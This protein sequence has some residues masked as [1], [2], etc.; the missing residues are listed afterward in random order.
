[1]TTKSLIR[2]WVQ[3][4][5][6]ISSVELARHAKIARQVATRHLNDLIA[7]GE[8]HRTG[9]TKS[10]LYFWGPSKQ[11]IL[12]K[13]H[14]AKTRRGLSE[15]EVFLEIESALHFKKTLS[16][17]GNQIAIYSFSEM[18]NNAIDHSSSA[19]ISIDVSITNGIFAFSIKDSG[20]G[21]FNRLKKG[22]KLKTDLEAIEFLFKG[23]HTTF[24]E[25]HSGQGIFYTS[26]IADKF[27]IRSN[28]LTVL[29]DNIKED[30]IITSSKKIKGTEVSFQIKA[31]TKKS[32]EKLFKDYANEDFEFDK[33][34]VRIKLNSATDLVSRS[35]ARRV[36][37]GMEKFKRLIFDFN[38]IKG[39]GQAF[40][41]EIFRVY[42]QLNP[43]VEISY[44]NANE[45][46]TFM[47]KRAGK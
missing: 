42:P 46:V 12:N 44:I 27:Q 34:V 15:H 10:A 1:M 5:N 21:I 4:S 20:I 39:I 13:L 23:K 28:E 8:I 18:L 7:A 3:K 37:I 17:A 9:S 19:L 43:G 11:V 14:M 16:K 36:L 30:Q 47:I 24:P 29:T 31:K 22:F 33:N 2:K 38:K 25:R 32:L 40:A 41:D 26:R 45:P 6:G 35:Q